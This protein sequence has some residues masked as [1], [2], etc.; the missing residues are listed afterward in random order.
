MLKRTPPT[1]EVVW[2]LLWLWRNFVKSNKITPEHIIW[3]ILIWFCRLQ[4]YNRDPVLQPRG[5][6]FKGHGL[7]KDRGSNKRQFFFYILFSISI[8]K[9]VKCEFKLWVKS[10]WMKS[11]INKT[12]ILSPTLFQEFRGHNLLHVSHKYIG[13]KQPEWWPLTSEAIISKVLCSNHRLQKSM[14]VTFVTSSTG[15]C[16]FSCFSFLLPP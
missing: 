3:V 14:D 13:Q 2:R 5:V 15:G 8:S 7:L 4:L 9:W 6:E 1:C 11:I 10:C 16:T 12:D